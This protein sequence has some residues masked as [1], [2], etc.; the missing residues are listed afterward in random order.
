MIEV[1]LEGSY[2]SAEDRRR[3]Y[4]IPQ[5]ELPP[6]TQLQERLAKAFGISAEEYARCLLALE[7]G[8][9]RREERARR[10]GAV[11]EEIAK[12]IDPDFQVTHII[13]N[14][15]SGRLLFRICKGPLE[16]QR[17][18]PKE[19]GDSILD[20]PGWGRLPEL[21]SIVEETV[22]RMKERLARP[23]KAAV[24]IDREA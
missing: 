6:L 3:A 7:I 5:E 4:Q 17:A 23:R 22:A 12:E 9:K 24:D 20:E 15:S 11:V 14:A 16:V 13:D 8:N 18:F 19:L 21:A 10:L 1:V 2:T